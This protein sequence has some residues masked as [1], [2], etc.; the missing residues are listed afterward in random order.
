MCFFIVQLLFIHILS[1][2][3]DVGA[4]PR[5]I[6]GLANQVGKGTSNGSTLD[7]EWLPILLREFYVELI[8]LAWN[9]DLQMWIIGH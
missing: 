6:I 3:I 5:D 2:G 7:P 1:I 8:P 4:S 9:C